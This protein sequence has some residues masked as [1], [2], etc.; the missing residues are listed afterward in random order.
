[1]LSL[2][3][4]LLIGA[5]LVASVVAVLPGEQAAASPVG[6]RQAGVHRVDARATDV[7]RLAFYGGQTAAVVLD[8]DGDT[9]LDL[10]VYDE[11]GNLIGSDTDGSDT[12]VVRFRP[13]WTGSFRI[14]VR[15]L[16]TVY[17][18]YAIVAA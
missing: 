9:D 17:N 8:G 12:C 1:M 4:K 14:E 15:N 2:T 10:Y 6:G 13:R 16:G 5:T 11:N 7:F 18:E 3:K